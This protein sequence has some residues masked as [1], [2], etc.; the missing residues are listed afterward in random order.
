[1]HITHIETIPIH[2][3]IR[4]GLAPAAAEGI[5]AYYVVLLL[6]TDAGFVGLGEATV[7]PSWSAETARQCAVTLE[8]L[9]PLLVGTDPTRVTACCQRLDQEVRLPAFSRA[10][11][12]MALWDLAGKA[13]GIPLHQLWGGRVR[14]RVPV[15]MVIG[16]GDVDEAVQL[17]EDLLQAGARALKLKVGVDR[18][19]EVERVGSVRALVGNDIALGI[20]AGGG[21]NSLTARE[22]MEEL[23]ACHLSYVEQ[24]I[25][26]GSTRLLARIKSGSA[27]PIVADES[28]TT[29]AEA[30]TVA[31]AQAATVLSVSPGKNGGLAA[32]V[33]IVHVARAAGLACQLGGNFELGIATAAML[34][35][36]V[37]VP[38]ILSE[39]YPAD[40]AGPLYHEND[41]LREPLPLGPESAA[42]PERPGLGVELDPG[43]VER[44]R[45]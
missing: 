13:A 39:R 30:W 22:A 21:W 15:Q 43:Q 28:V 3:P 18:A 1:M 2:M 33:E 41:L 11:V 8:Q 38:G 31:S 36:A 45:A 29:L 7:V 37:A 14:E 26:A 20:D 6:H 34:H 25:A 10:A 5:E 4:A 9:A 32:A 42:A 27:V 19:L 40:L 24:P 17:A 16:A 35:L 44:W 12:E 23:E